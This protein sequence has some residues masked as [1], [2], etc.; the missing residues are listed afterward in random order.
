MKRYFQDYWSGIKPAFQ[1]HGDKLLFGIALAILAAVLIVNFAGK[2]PIARMN[3]PSI[4]FTQWWQDYLEKDT[5][6]VLVNEFESIHKNIK[7]EINESSR[8]DMRRGLFSPGSE[9]AFSGDI[10]ALDPLWVPELLKK[11][12]IEPPDSDMPLLSFIDILY[13]NVEILKE[14]GFTKPPKTR[15]EFLNCLRAVTSAENGRW[16]LITE[17]IYDDFFPWIWSAGAQLIKDGKPAL[18]SRQVVDSLS[19]FAQLEKEGSIA[20]SAPGYGKLE[21]FISGRAVFMIAPANEIAIVRE[22]MGEEKFSVSSVPTPDNYAGKTFSGSAGWTVGINSASAHIEEAKLFAAFLADNVPLLAKKAGAIP[23]NGS[24]APSP[25]SPYSKV[26]DLAFAAEI[27]RDFNG[28]PWTELE[29][30]FKEELNALFAE[31]SSPAET[32]A[33]IQKRWEEALLPF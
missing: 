10:L 25:D 12:V 3:I 2:K 5:L 18:T 20:P 8:E 7:I 11:G 1:K 9:T 32:A 28:L 6:Q 19:F 31:E 24:S 15:T 16:G 4:V 27:A 23:E 30:I 13:Y 21:D 22:R 29:E 26:W 14:A 33:A 17:G